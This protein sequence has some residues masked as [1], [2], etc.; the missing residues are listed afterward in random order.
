MHS[1]V[2]IDL[3]KAIILEARE[4]LSEELE[5]KIKLKSSQEEIKTIGANSEIINQR[6]EL[7][8]KNMSQNLKNNKDQY[9]K[10]VV[11]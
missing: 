4:G 9:N 8:R 3:K 10:K 6:I 11:H 2:V 7:K 5:T 1:E